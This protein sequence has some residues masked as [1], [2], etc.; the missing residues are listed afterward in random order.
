MFKAILITFIVTL[1]FS[2][3]IKKWLA[4]LWAKITLWI[5]QKFGSAATK[6]KDK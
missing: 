6:L 5:K 3:L 2:G 4:I 1:V